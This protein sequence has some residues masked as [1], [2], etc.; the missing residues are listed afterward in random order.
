MVDITQGKFEQFVGQDRSCICEAKKRMVRKNRSQS[1]GSSMQD[2]LMTEAAEA[3]MAMHNLNFF[4]YYYISEH[5][6]EREDSRHRRLAVDDQKWN[7][8][9]LEA[10]GKVVHSGAALICMSNNNDLVAPINKLLVANQPP[11]NADLLG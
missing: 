1:H 3:G 8:V 9:D 5:R 7:V 2:G 10:I 4:S 11:L 6:K